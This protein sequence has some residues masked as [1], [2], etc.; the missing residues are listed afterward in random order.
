MGVAIYIVVEL[1]LGLGSFAAFHSGHTYWGWG[2]L[3]AFVIGLLPVVGDDAF[4]FLT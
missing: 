1:A 4:D 3:V 2:L